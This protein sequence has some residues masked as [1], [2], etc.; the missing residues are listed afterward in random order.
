MVAIDLIFNQWE[1]TYNIEVGVC[2]EVHIHSTA[3]TLSLHCW[4]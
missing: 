2:I 1:A 4:I 3:N